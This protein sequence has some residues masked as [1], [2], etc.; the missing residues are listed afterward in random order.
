M[1]LESFARLK[2][3]LSRAETLCLSDASLSELLEPWAPPDFDSGKVK[4]DEESVE[5]KAATSPPAKPM[6]KKVPAVSVQS[7]DWRRDAAEAQHSTAANSSTPPWRR[8]ASMTE[9]APAPQ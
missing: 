2:E 6:S 1:T 3:E 7:L 8:P 5:E 9:A 4:H